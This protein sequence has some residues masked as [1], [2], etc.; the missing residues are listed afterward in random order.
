MEAK[1]PTRHDG[2][3]H[4]IPCVQYRFYNGE[5]RHVGAIVALTVNSRALVTIEIVSNVLLDVGIPRHKPPNPQHQSEYTYAR[6]SFLGGMLNAKLGIRAPEF[7]RRQA[8]LRVYFRPFVLQFYFLHVCRHSQVALG[9]VLFC[10]PYVDRT[11][12]E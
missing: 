12:I 6:S 3:H 5:V 10:F 11:G 4:L 8:H 2:P 1:F 9:P 7:G